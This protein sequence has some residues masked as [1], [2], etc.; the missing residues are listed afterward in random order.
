MA[1]VNQV[2]GLLQQC[3]KQ[4]QNGGFGGNAWAYL[5]I[6][7][8]AD[9]YTQA[10]EREYPVNIQ[11]TLAFH[12][13]GEWESEVVS[14]MRAVSRGFLILVHSNHLY[15]SWGAVRNSDILSDY[16]TS[17]KLILHRGSYPQAGMMVS[18]LEF[19]SKLGKRESVNWRNGKH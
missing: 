19:K 12:H 13:S 18:Q 14:V 16:L 4:E 17:R 15:R 11:F 5:I 2:E 9:L 10:N 1:V 7:L 8:L 3:R 6:T